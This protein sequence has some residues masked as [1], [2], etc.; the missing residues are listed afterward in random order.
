MTARARWGIAFAAVAIVAILGATI[1]ALQVARDARSVLALAGDGRLSV[2]QDRPPACLLSVG[3]GTGSDPVGGVGEACA[4]LGRLHTTAQPIFLVLG[5]LGLVPGFGGAEQIPALM[6]VAVGF[7]RAARIAQSLL[8]ELDAAPGSSGERVLALARRR[9]SDLRKL[10]D[11]LNNALE[12]EARLDESRFTGV[13]AP[14]GSAVRRLRA[15]RPAI[16]TARD[17]A[18]DAEA[19]VAEALGADGPRTYL[20]LGQNNEELRATGGFIGTIGVMTVDRGRIL[21]SDFRSSYD[22]DGTTEYAQP[23]PAPLMQYMGFARWYMR[24]ANWWIDYQESAREIRRFWSESQGGTIHGVIAVDR[25]ALDLVLGALGGVDVPE[26]G[27]FV[28][29]A[30]A[31]ESLDRQRRQVA[32]QRNHAAYH[33]TKTALLNALSKAIMARALL[34]PPADALPA[35][36]ASLICGLETKHILLNFAHPGLASLISGVGWD[37]RVAAQSGDVLAIVDTSVS[38]GKTAPYLRKSAVYRRAPDGSVALTVRYENGY[39]PVP[40]GQWDPLVDGTFFDWRAGVFR[41]VQGAWVGFIRI[42][43]PPGTTVGDWTGWDDRVTRLPDEGGL[44]TMGGP[45]LVYPGQAHQVTLSYRLPVEIRASPL[46]VIAQAGGIAYDLHVLY[47]SGPA[48]HRTIA[49][50]DTVVTAG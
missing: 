8:P 5:P 32:V 20:I 15:L 23:P 45:I 38:Y 16:E 11:E 50:R 13:L 22:W 17:A 40:G 41:R 19:I 7:C 3:P 49:D 29:A 6:D 9:S 43:L 48:V 44:L 24:D 10:A 4:A 35:I 47:P 26:L 39:T 34:D 46:Q 42:L 31:T 25:G 12:I 30:Q 37:G 1:P 27:G 18:H 2:G 21:R 36:G 28:T 14:A 33:E